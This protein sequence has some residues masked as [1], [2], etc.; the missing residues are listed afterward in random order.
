MSQTIYPIGTLI[1]NT[2][3]DRFGIVCEPKDSE[4]VTQDRLWAYWGEYPDHQN[5]R[6]K[7]FVYMSLY[8]NYIVVLKYPGPSNQKELALEWTLE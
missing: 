2:Y 6:H 5:R 3:L 4:H 8:R 7:T 1:H